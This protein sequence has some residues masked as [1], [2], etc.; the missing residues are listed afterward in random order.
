MPCVT[1]DLQILSSHCPEF[2]YTLGMLIVHTTLKYSEIHGL[3]CFAAQDI[4]KG[5]VVWKLD[6]EFDLI[7]KV[8]DLQL[9]PAP[10]VQ[11]LKMYSYRPIDSAE[12]VLILCCDHARHMNHS[13]EPNLLEGVDGSNIAAR[14][15]K[16]G[17]ELTCDYTLFDKDID[18]KLSF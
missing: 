8:K 4:K 2:H 1:K 16:A 6:T 13:T 5:E 3:G 11:F 15:I 10:F 9:H 14:D 17:E 7:F 12:D 18:H